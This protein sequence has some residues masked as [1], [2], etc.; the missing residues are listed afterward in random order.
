MNLTD[1][2]YTR[3]IAL[4]GEPDPQQKLMLHTLST[5]AN[6]TIAAELRQD[7]DLFPCREALCIAGSLYVVADYLE[8]DETHSV[9]RFTVGD[10]TIHRT[11]AAAGAK[12]LRQQADRMLQP[13]RCDRFSFRRV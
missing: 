5:A 12:M 2:I 13:Y 4:L 1:E 8:M 3:A 7:L 9:E 10:M 6:G 11:N